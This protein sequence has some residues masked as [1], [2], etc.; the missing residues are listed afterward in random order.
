MLANVQQEFH[1]MIENR[2]RNEGKWI[3]IFCFYEELAYPG[4]GKVRG[5]MF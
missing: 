1:A 5:Q 3:D 4:I 2:R